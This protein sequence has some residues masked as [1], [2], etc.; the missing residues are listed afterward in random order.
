MRFSY[1]AVSVFIMVGYLWH[2]SDDA[3]VFQYSLRYLFFLIGLFLVLF[4]FIPFLLKKVI[5]KVGIKNL[6]F[7]SIPSFFIL[8]LV[9]FFFHYKYYWEQIHPFDPF[10][11]INPPLFTISKEKEPNEYRI[12][13]L[14]GSTT[15]NLDLPEDKRYPALLQK[16]LA[17]KYPHLKIT[18]M[19]GGRD[20]FTTKHSL[21]HY[22]T[23]CRDFKP[24]L[25]IIM[26]AINDL[27]RSFSAQ[28]AIGDYN[29]LYSHYY[30]PSINGARPPTFEKILWGEIR[31]WFT[32][33]PLLNYFFDVHKY[34]QIGEGSDVGLDKFKS[35]QPFE[36][37]L[38]A[39]ADY[40]KSDGAKCVIVSQPFLYKREMTVEE[41]DVL[42]FAFHFC[43]EKNGS[44]PNHTSML[45]AMNKFNSTAQKVAQSSNVFFVD[46]E[47]EIPKT[48]DYF[49]DDVHY[50]IKGA[51]VMAHAIAEAIVQ[52]KLIALPDSAP[53]HPLSLQASYGDNL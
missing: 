9:Y 6:L 2:K 41:K 50:T 39:L 26:H 1:F 49:R 43:T 8:L 47:K 32:H 16:L 46:A 28:T 20:W 23:Y 3:V 12:L 36:R 40:I 21:I 38:R 15:A 24:D 25:V 35:I 5:N 29:E 52:Y 45:E 42:E 27:V 48:L 19:N 13:T 53:F 22:T 18:V 33:T 7:A 11:Q 51:A 17:L 14:G 44:H 37:N 4:L 10:L 31:F 34:G 30:G